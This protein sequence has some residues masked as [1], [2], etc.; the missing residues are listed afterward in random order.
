MSELAEA[1]RQIQIA[2]ETILKAK[3]IISKLKSENRELHKFV[4]ISEELKTF[5]FNPSN[6]EILNEESYL[7]IFLFQ[8]HC[9]YTSLIKLIVFN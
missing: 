2:N 4:L 6:L 8:N 5:G 3:Q 9:F 1:N 7:Y